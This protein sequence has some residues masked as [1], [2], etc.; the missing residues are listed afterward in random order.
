MPFTKTPHENT[1]EIAIRKVRPSARM[2]E[3]ATDGSAAMDLRACLDAPITI[4]PGGHASLHTGLAM[5]LP[6]SC[7]AAL[8]FSRSGHGFRQAVTL[9]NSVGV[10]DAD[11]R[12]EI[13]V[14]LINGGDAPF[15]V[16]DGDRIAQMAILPVCR[17][18]VSQTDELPPSLRGEG[19][20]GSTGDS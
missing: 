13:V 4:Q 8:L 11:Y 16:K 5:A 9:V 6:S 14:G 3:Y 18:V 15:V 17:A 1:V 2:P 7:Y 10:V 19:G 20:L 12:G